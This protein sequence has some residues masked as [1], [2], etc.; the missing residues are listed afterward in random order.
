MDS[1]L[2]RNDKHKK[3]AFIPVNPVYF[4]LIVDYPQHAIRNTHY[5]IRTK[6]AVSRRFFWNMLDA[7]RTVNYDMHIT[8]LVS[9]EW[10]IEKYRSKKSKKGKRQK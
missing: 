7:E 1:C 6:N 2:R 10:G 9:S 5:A 3:S 4:K 8:I